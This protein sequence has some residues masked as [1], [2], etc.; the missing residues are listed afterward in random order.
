MQAILE[1]KRSG[2]IATFEVPDPELRPGGILVRT[3]F[4]AIS[5]GT[6]RAKVE[7]SKKSLLGKALERPDLVQQ[8]ITF[9][10]EQG[11]R[12]A[13]EKVQA[14][15]DQLTPLGYSCS[16]VVTAVGEGVTEFLPGDR[17][18]CG[19]G[20]YAN[21]CSVNFVP[22]N[23]A[24]KVPD[25]VALDAAALAT[26]GAIAMQGLRQAQ[27]SFGET[28]VVIGAGLLG[29]LTIQMAR[30]AGCKTIAID[31]NPDR[32]TKAAA[33]GATHGFVNTDPNLERAVGNISRY[34]AD[35]VIITAGVNSNEP[36][37]LAARLCRERAR[38]VVVGAVSLD[39]S[40]QH[41][42]H[43]ELSIHMSRSYGPGRYDA[44]YEELGQDYPVGYVRWTEQRNMEAF[45][46]LIASGAI[47]V[48][49][50]LRSRFPAEEGAKGYQSLQDPGIYTSLISY[51]SAE[52]GSRPLARPAT[53]NPKGRVRVGCIGAGGFA[54]S[55][56]FPKLAAASFVD[57]HSVATASGVAAESAKKAFRFSQAQTP[58]DLIEDPT[59]DAVFVL[60]RHDSHAQYVRQ[61]LS[62]GKAV[63]VEKPLAVDLEQV[64]AITLAHD[65]FVSS[66]RSP[67]LVVGFNRRFA[68]ATEDLRRF[69]EGRNEPM[70]I[71]IAVNA[72]YLPLDHWVHQ[73]GGRF[74]GE[75]CHFVD[76][77]RSVV[78]SP[79]RQVFAS[80]LPNGSRYAGD[81]VC[82]QLQF[83]D[84]S[85][86]SIHY[87]A[88]GERTVPKE[89]FEVNCEAGMAILTDF[90]MLE[91]FRGGASKTKKYSM[92]K[93]H[94]RLLTLTLEAI[95]DGRPSPIPFPE[96]VEV[97]RAT[98]LVVE[99]SARGVP[100]MVETPS[101]A[102]PQIQAVGVRGGD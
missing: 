39:V 61:A 71:R 29:V 16:G 70:M 43:K 94:Q 84:G 90:K 82:A 64:E 78:Q 72:G 15:L 13:Y 20:G 3:A 2:T 12:A 22:K 30:A 66:G 49:P 100:L 56:I 32:V 8:V 21:H 74:I 47:S 92:D 5:A 63:F 55:M 81:N 67:F 51:A 91:T 93:G 18:A 86:A 24:V 46:D 54:R 69:F 98:C 1:D 19:G 4:S 34:G 40:R 14:K 60:S 75:G 80:A 9:A 52:A 45:L 37:E 95:R 28:V 58:A 35:A 102:I 77:A 25:P 83:E 44:N 10:K 27:V 65:E 87:F 36:I 101:G 11:I 17:V 68:P 23:L 96:L 62:A 73:D 59:V 6:E 50:L 33:F 7:T 99:S 57:M 38:I 88:N 97:S 42:Y 53:V 79:I 26:I 48:E 85:Q 76:W 31:A 41:V 89:R